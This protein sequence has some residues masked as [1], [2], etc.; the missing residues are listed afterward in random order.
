MSTTAAILA[1][2]KGSYQRALVLGNETWSGSSLT[3]RAR[4]YGG[5]YARS[6]R[7]LLA[8]IESSGLGYLTI[9]ERG[10]IILMLGRPPGYC[11][12]RP[13]AVGTAWV[14]DGKTILDEMIEALDESRN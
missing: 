5:H 6:R 9:G 13:V 14:P 8:R 4:N 7:N 1:L 2:C 12:P 11:V 10:K 3:G